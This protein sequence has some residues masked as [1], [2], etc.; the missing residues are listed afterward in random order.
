VALAYHD[1][2]VPGEPQ[3]RITLYKRLP[4][5][6]GGQDVANPA[7]TAKLNTPSH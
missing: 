2:Y 7:S 3:R 6:V 5:A 1:C 4:T